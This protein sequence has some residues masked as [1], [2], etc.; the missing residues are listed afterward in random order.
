[1]S[2]TSPGA[3]GLMYTDPSDHVSI[4]IARSMV[5][6][7]TTP[8]GGP[9]INTDCVKFAVVL[10]ASS[11]MSGAAT[12]VGTIGAPVYPA[13]G[14]DRTG[15]SS[16]GLAAVLIDVVSAPS[17]SCEYSSLSRGG[18][19]LSSEAELGLNDFAVHTSIVASVIS[20]VGGDTNTFV[21]S[22]K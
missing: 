16:S 6:S 18:I 8:H 10:V 4:E 12:I 21:S 22:V 1:M 17:A 5:S 19:D 7:P 20:V 11:S 14:P 2:G 15:G 3:N 9:N 13:S